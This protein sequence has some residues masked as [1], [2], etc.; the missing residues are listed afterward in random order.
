MRFPLS[1]LRQREARPEAGEPRV[2]PAPNSRDSF[3]AT[4]AATIVLAV[5]LLAAGGDGRILEIAAIGAAIVAAYAADWASPRVL[6]VLAAAVYL[7][8]EAL[9]SRFSYD[10]YWTHIFVLGA[11]GIAIFGAAIARR[12]REE[13]RRAFERAIARLDESRNEDVVERLLAGGEQ[14]STLERE[15]KRSRRHEHA[16]S[17]LLVRPDEVEDVALRHGQS[18]VHDVLRVVAEIVGRHSRV[19]DCAYRH[20][21]YDICVLLPE[22]GTAG[23]RVAAERFRLAVASERMSFGPG[24]PVNLSVSI[25]ASTFPVATSQE[26][27]LSSAEEALERAV[28]LGGNRT[29]LS[30]LPEDAPPGWALG[31]DAEPAPTA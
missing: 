29:V 11:T 18:G 25:G 1:R 30:S 4:I 27:L 24:D 12:R 3:V 16:A 5:V 20:G 10:Y 9:E 19:S 28:E 15:L 22:T 21:S 17:M 23:A 8:D 6:T 31:A 26:E 7:A 13:H 2:E 14:P